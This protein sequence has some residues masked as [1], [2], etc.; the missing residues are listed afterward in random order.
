MYTESRD[1]NG[2][3]SKHQLTHKSFVALVG[4][5]KNYPFWT[6]VEVTPSTRT[7]KLISIVHSETVIFK[8]DS[9]FMQ[10]IKVLE[11]HF[12]ITLL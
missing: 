5:T 7:V 9:V 2:E 12:N 3:L 4:Y 6:E 11:E 10:Y 8:T 1:K